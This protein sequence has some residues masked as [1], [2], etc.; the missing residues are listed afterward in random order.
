LCEAAWALGG[1]AARGLDVRVTREAAA[2]SRRRRRA[3]L[4]AAAASVAVV[5][6]TLM[7]RQQEP[8][9]VVW[10]T[11]PGEQRTV[12]LADGSRVTLNTRTTL[13]VRLGDDER[14]L[15]MLEGEAYFAVA[16]DAERPFVVSTALGSARAVGTRFNVLLDADR[17]EVATEEGKVLVHAPG[18]AD[19]AVLSTAGTRATVVRG[20]GRPSLD[21]A[22]LARIQN[23]RERRLEFTSVPLDDVLREFSRYTARPVRAATPEIGRVQVS[24]VLKAGDVEALRAPPARGR[25]GGHAAVTASFPGS[26]PA[27]GALPRRC[28]SSRAPRG[29]A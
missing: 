19:A 16:P 9:P 15:A 8:E 23:W 2:P 25:V 10:R 11:A 22:D 18:E 3:L 29:R 6:G 1:D 4:V 28:G 20:V 26:M 21:T 14:A 27:S 7:L 17:V 5:A 13:E 12:V 24:A